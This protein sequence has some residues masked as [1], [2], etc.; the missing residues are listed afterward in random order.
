MWLQGDTT[1]ARALL[2]DALA[3]GTEGEADFSAANALHFV[4]WIDAMES[5]PSALTNAQ[6]ALEAAVEMQFPFY[7]G[8]NTVLLGSALARAGETEAGLGEI[9]TGM[10]TLEAT[11]TRLVQS[12]YLALLAQAQRQAGAA[13]EALASVSQALEFV[14][15]TGERFWEAELHRL[16]GELLL[17]ESQPRPS[18]AEG[19]FRSALAIARAQGAKS[20]EDRAAQSLARLSI[21][22]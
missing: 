11:G 15:L 21:G 17:D 13:D 1:R 12:F 4:A 18:E 2:N 9:Q 10:A 19:E 16:T 14:E 8:M 5:A 6:R 3:A 22:A 20:L 7:V